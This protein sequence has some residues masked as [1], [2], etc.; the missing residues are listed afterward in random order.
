YQ[1][2]NHEELASELGVHESL[3]RRWMGKTG[4]Q[5]CLPTK[6][7]WIKLKQMVQF[8]DKYDKQMTEM[9]EVDKAVFRK[10]FNDDTRLFTKGFEQKKVNDGRSTPIDNPFQQIGRAHV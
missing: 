3:V 1:K 2:F 4:D 9:I 5:H 7:E 6:E 10:Q 8:D